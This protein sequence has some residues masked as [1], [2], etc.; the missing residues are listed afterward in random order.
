M[1]NLKEHKKIFALLILAL[2]VLV[3]ITI[4]FTDKP[5]TTVENGTFYDL[6]ADENATAGG[7]EAKSQAEVEAELNAKVAEGMINVSMNTNPVFTDGIGNVLIVNDQMNNYPQIVEIYDE[8]QNLIYK[9]GLIQVGSKVETA[10]LQGS[11]TTGDYKCIATFN[12]VNPTTGELAGRANVNIV[13]TV[14]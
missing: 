10:T 9:S 6:T 5:E 7:I 8:N 13:V 12:A 11:L 1:K 2:L 14:K 4:C 3:G